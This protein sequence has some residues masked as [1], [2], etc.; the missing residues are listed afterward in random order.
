[1]AKQSPLDSVY[2]LSNIS[3]VT[4]LTTHAHTKNYRNQLTY[5]GVTGRQA[6][7][8]ILRHSVY[9]QLYTRRASLHESASTRV[10]RSTAPTLAASPPPGSIN[11]CRPRR[12]CSR[13]DAAYWLSVRTGQTDG[14]TD[15]RTSDRYTDA[16][17]MLC[18]YR[19][20][21]GS[22]A[23]HPSLYLALRARPWLR[24]SQSYDL[25]DVD[26]TLMLFAAAT[27]CSRTQSWQ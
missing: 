12:G 21:S 9:I 10:R 19:V 2:S 26:T 13:P 23:R 25:S 22:A 4:K 17:R 18:L 5:I 6:S 7:V 15:G 8:V 3:T 11:I 14:R 24:M 1:M 16:S 20:T 27:A